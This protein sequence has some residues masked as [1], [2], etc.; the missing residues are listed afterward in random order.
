M[1]RIAII[2]TGLIG[3]SIGL[4]LHQESAIKDLEVV[5]SDY[6]AG[7]LKHAEKIGAIDTAMRNAR[8]A[9]KDASLVILATPVLALRRVMAEIAPALGNGAIVTDTGSTKVEVMTWAQ[10][11]LPRTVSFVGGHPMA[12]K[13]ESGPDHADGTLFEGARW[14]IVPMANASESSLKTVRDLVSIMGATEMFMDAGEHDAYVAAISHLPMMAATAM[15]TMVNDS[16]AWPELSLLA[17][18]GFKDTTRLAGTEPNVAFDIAITNR[19]QIVHWIE[20]YREALRELQ[21]R[22]SDEQGEEEFFRYIAQANWDY[23][24]YRTGNV[25]RQEVDE[26]M[27]PIPKTDL[28]NLFMGEALASKMRDLTAASDARLEELDRKQRLTRRE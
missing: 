20:R 13:T 15:F 18:G 27:A 16:E 24:G 11:E 1:P 26:K 10:T 21:E 3:A 7:H 12:G 22:L 8:A 9:V 17:A 14:A 6:I 28:G 25:G 4:R 5:G 2:G 19:T 23:T